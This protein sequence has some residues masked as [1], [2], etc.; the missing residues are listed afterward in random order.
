MRSGETCRLF[1]PAPIGLFAATA[2]LEDEILTKHPRKI[3]TISMTQP[4]ILITRSPHQSSE[5]AERL[6]ASGIDPIL[7]PTIE[8]V[9]PTTFAPLDAAIGDLNTDR[10]SVV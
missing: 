6:R 7:I 2:N 9:E 5:L 3:S 4:R 10:K 1:V 8:I